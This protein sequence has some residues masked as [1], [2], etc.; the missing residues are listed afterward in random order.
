MNLWKVRTTFV[1]KGKLENPNENNVQLSRIQMKQCVT[2]TKLSKPWWWAPLN[3]YM[4]KNSRR[5]YLGEATLASSFNLFALWSGFSNPLDYW[6]ITVS[7][8][9]MEWCPNRCSF[10]DF[11]DLVSSSE[12]LLRSV[13]HGTTMA[14]AD[15]PFLWCR[16]N[17]IFNLRRTACY[18]RNKMLWFLM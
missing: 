7:L 9:C 16:F 10:N 4:H 8:F 17:A 13:K 15:W 18:W 5:A 11:V 1:N 6:W 2:A 3:S 14:F 12:R